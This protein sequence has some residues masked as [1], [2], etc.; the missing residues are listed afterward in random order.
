[1]LHRHC[2]VWMVEVDLPIEEDA[3]T[4]YLHAQVCVR[5][6][7]LEFWIEAFDIRPIELISFLKVVEWRHC[8]YREGPKG[9]WVVAKEVGHFDKF[10]DLG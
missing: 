4:T 10:L 6:G 8:W 9:E 3:M 2:V 7:R 5:V 1:M